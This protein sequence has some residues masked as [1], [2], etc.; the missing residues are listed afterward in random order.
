MTLLERV[1]RTPFVRLLYAAPVLVWAY[2]YV[3]SCAGA[4]WYGFPS[5][6]VVVVGVTG[7]K[8]KTTTVELASSILEAAGKKTAFLSS[9]HIKVGERIEKNKSGNTMPEGFLVQR[10]LWEALRARC[11]YAL[12]EVTSQGVAM[13]RH[14]FISWNFG[15]ATN[16]APEHIEA[17]GSFEDYRNAKLAFLR[18]VIRNQGIAFINGDD[19][20]CAFF[21]E[22]LKGKKIVIVYS[23]HDAHVRNLLSRPSFLRASEDPT[24]AFILSD[25]NEENIAAVEAFGRYLK[26][27]ENVIEAGIRSFRGVPGRME[28]VQG[29]GITVVVDYAHTPD[30]LDAAYAAIRK[31]IS[32]EGGEPR[33]LLCVLGAAGGGRDKW[34]RPEMGRVAAQY[35]DNIFLTNEDAY[36][37]DPMAIVADIS[38]GIPVGWQGGVEEILDR[39]EALARAISVAREGDFVIATGKGNESWIHG[40]DGEKIPWNERQVVEKLLGLGESAV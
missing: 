9:A 28:F 37:E 10:F 11:D 26:L 38:S 17:H 32:R 14:R 27:P 15:I 36:D 34:K 1:K 8:G 39:R 2:H 31:K 7:T 30:S 20:G 18:R 3:L 13:S 22:A 21:I 4:A 24:P 25:F 16:L 40:A 29:R 33:R 35:C 6:R 12:I 23:R 19:P 5:R